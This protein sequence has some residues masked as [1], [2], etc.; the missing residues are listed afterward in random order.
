RSGSPQNTERTRSSPGP[1]CSGVSRGSASRRCARRQPG[2]FI[3]TPPFEP[4]R[5]IVTALQERGL[6]VAIGGSAVL[7]ALG[8]VDTVRDW[9]ITVE[10]DPDAVGRIL[11]SLDL[12]VAD[13][14]EHM[15]PFATEQRFVVDAGDHEID[16]LVGFALRDGQTV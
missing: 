7:A 16:V 15:P 6:Q 10:G 3:R 8:L 14:T 1:R 2:M 13:R 4:V 12:T 9:D 5:S 11:D